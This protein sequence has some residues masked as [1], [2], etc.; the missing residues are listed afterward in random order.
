MRNFSTEGIILKKR[1]RDEHD[2]YI[3]L[4]SPSL[5][6]INAVARGARRIASSFA[7]HL[8]PL[9]V[10]EFELYLSARSYTITQCRSKETFKKIRGSL[11]KTLMA[12][13]AC[14]IFEKTAYSTE[15][16]HEFFTL[17]KSALD[18]FGNSKK[19]VLALESFKIKLM[20]LAG[21]LPDIR[22]YAKTADTDGETI[23]HNI[24]KL[25]NYICLC[26][27][28]AIEKISLS[29]PEENTL[30][31]T[32]DAFLRNYLDC[33]IASEEVLQSMS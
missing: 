28:A 22:Q 33:K 20:Q 29:K 25:I 4:F 12:S 18:N 19:P 11:N 26:D 16:S 30:K 21:V 2:H 8:E 23:P 31:R 10:C 7:G 27:F 3:T 13:M 24:I 1:N 32:A 14:E 17:F 5:G 15:Q 6:R 9:N